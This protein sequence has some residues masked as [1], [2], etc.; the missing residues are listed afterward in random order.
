MFDISIRFSSNTYT[1]FVTI[2]YFET[3][4]NLLSML[5]TTLIN[6]GHLTCLTV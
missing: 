6:T 3:I 2:F 1:L 4:G 5:N